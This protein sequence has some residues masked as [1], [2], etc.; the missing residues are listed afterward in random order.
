M[1]SP[2]S[3]VLLPPS[4]MQ[5]IDFYLISTPLSIRQLLLALFI[6]AITLF[7]NAPVFCSPHRDRPPLQSPSVHL[8]AVNPTRPL[9][10]SFESLLL[11]EPVNSFVSMES[12]QQLLNILDAFVEE[13][14]IHNVREDLAFERLTATENL[15][16]YEMNSF[17]SLIDDD[18]SN[19][20][21]TA[22]DEP[23]TCVDNIASIVVSSTPP[24]KVCNTSL[25]MLSKTTNRI[26]YTTA[27]AIH[28]TLLRTM[29][30]YST[31]L[32]A[33]T[34]SAVSQIPKRKKMPILKKI[35][36]HQ[37]KRYRI[38]LTENHL[39]RLF[40]RFSLNTALVTSD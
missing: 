2:S 25:T 27:P 28:C 11:C 38:Q 26:V 18:L 10:T 23:S 31:S 29:T 34:A 39:N 21:S 6:K 19:S 37:F 5:L 30:Y 13:T 20:S 33:T 8:A 12:Y 15:P 16:Y 35:T 40:K 17:E 3:C 22:H 7:K 24:A 9:R 1:T 36:Q 32:L 14:P 4:H